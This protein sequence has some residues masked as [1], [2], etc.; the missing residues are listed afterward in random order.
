MVELRFGTAEDAAAIAALH[1][2]SWRRH[3]RGA[4]SDA[5]LDGDVV[6]DRLAVWSERLAEPSEAFVTIV[7]EQDGALVGFAHTVLDEDDEWGA[8]LDNLHV[9]HTLQRSGIGVRLVVATAAEVVRRRPGS[10]LHLWV[11]EQNTQAQKFYESLGGQRVEGRLVNPPGGDPARL[12][13]APECF[14]YVWGGRWQTASTLLPS[15]SR[16]KAP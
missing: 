1:A 6:A 3:Y 7:A 8:L 11:L 10:G 2:D 5:Y 13:G 15:G 4:Y 16:T 9:T 12:A 14:R